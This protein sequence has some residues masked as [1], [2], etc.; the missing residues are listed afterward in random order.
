MCRLDIDVLK[1][2]LWN[3]LTPENLTE[4][5]NFL[6]SHDREADALD[7]IRQVSC[8]TTD[9][10]L[11]LAAYG[12][13]VQHTAHHHLMMTILRKALLVLPEVNDE[14]LTSVRYDIMLHLA[15]QLMALGHYDESM[16]LYADVLKASPK[17]NR[18][19]V[20]EHLSAC[21]LEAGRTEEA[22][23]VLESWLAEG[24]VSVPLY[25]NMGCALERLNRSEEAIAYYRKGVD[26]A[27]SHE[28]ISFGFG[29]CLLKAGHF[30]EGFQRYALRSPFV[31]NPSCWYVKDL[32]RLAPDVALEGKHILFYQEQGLGDTIQF[33]RFLPQILARGA[34]VTLAVPL[35]LLRL[36]RQ[37][38]PEV[39]VRLSNEVEAEPQ[40]QSQYHYGCPIAD[41]PYICGMKAEA[42][43]PPFAPYMT[44]P[45]QDAALFARHV[46]ERLEKEGRPTN[47]KRRLRVGLVWAGGKRFLARDVASDRRRSTNLQEMMGALAPAEVDFFSLQYGD[48]RQELTEGTPQPVYDLMDQVTD[49]ADCA[50]LMKTLDLVISVDTAPLHLAGALGIP[51]WLANRWDSCWRWGDEGTQSAWYPTLRIFRAHESSF[52]PVL[53]EIGE[54]LRSLVASSS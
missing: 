47:G 32:Y 44:V 51:V 12:V 29:I 7:I 45:E 27:P 21:L 11:L 49:M 1:K 25:N 48:P 5:G 50:A 18:L 38:F 26:L 4:A 37:S 42:D 39:D 43:I 20:G 19:A 14:H 33:I 17:Q 3:D 13:L 35:Q 23:T 34:R 15:D 8:E 52:V 53:N 9:V 31:I 46:S 54:A 41:L 16:G 30:E 6:Y 28:L 22:K 2:A 10:I 40:T 24:P 36:L